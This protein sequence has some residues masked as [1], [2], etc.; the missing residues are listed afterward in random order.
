MMANLSRL[1]VMAMCSFINPVMAAISAIE[2]HETLQEASEDG[3]FEIG[4]MHVKIGWHYG[5][6]GFRGSEIIGDAPVTAQQIIGLAKAD[7][8]LTSEQSVHILPEDMQ[9]NSH[10]IDTL[11]AEAYVGK[12]K[13]YTMPWEESDEVTKFEPVGSAKKEEPQISILML[14]YKRQDLRLDAD[15]PHCTIGRSQENNLSVDGK[16][17][18]RLHA[19][20]TYKHGSFYLKDV[21]TNGS[22]IVYAD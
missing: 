21:S 17:T 15:H 7:E 12:L 16:F 14:N 3:I 22:A 5:E 6:I 11:E 2:I 9:E 19:E 20:I 13:V 1:L 10:L 8:I 4:E 18:S